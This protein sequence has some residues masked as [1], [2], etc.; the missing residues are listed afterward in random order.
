M[1]RSGVA[2]NGAN[3]PP[4]EAQNQAQIGA[5]RAQTPLLRTGFDS[6]FEQFWSLYPKKRD[7]KDAEDIW[8]KL[9]PDKELNEKILRAVREQSTWRSWRKDGGQ[10]IPYAKTWLNGRKWDD[11][12]SAH[13]TGAGAS[14]AD[15]DFDDSYPGLYKAD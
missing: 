8:K 9:Q 13:D 7:K 14:G 1:R 12:P 10:F 3:A 15:D 4:G 5:N 6:S 2:Q 11:E